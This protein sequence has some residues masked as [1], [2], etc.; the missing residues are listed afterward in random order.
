MQTSKHRTDEKKAM[1]GKKGGGGAPDLEVGGVR[2]RLFRGLSLSPPSH[3]RTARLGPAA[4]AATLT[5]VATVAALVSVPAAAGVVE[6]EAAGPEDEAGQIPV[7]YRS[8]TGQ[9]LVKIRVKY[10]SITGQI[11]V[12]Y[13]SNTGQNSGQIWVKHRS[14]TGQIL[15]G[16][17]VVRREGRE[18]RPGASCP[19]NYAA[20]RRPS[21]RSGEAIR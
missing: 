13:R 15:V 5:R 9:I 14:N 18:M 6:H 20:G 3:H 17:C 1:D 10:W 12:K 2:T 19:D 4:A 21:V 7:K 16:Y 8:N 11:P